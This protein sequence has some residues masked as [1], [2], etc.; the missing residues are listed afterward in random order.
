MKKFVSAVAMALALSSGS[1]LAADL[2]A[3]K[4][5]PPAPPP[6]PPMWTGFYA[7]LNAGY[8]FGT[9]NQV[10]T[11]AFGAADPDAINLFN[12]NGSA[13]AISNLAL[14]GTA[15]ANTGFA[16][17]NQNGF[18][19]GAQIGYNW[20]WGTSFVFGVEADIQGAG[21]RG[22]GGHFGASADTLAFNYVNGG[23]AG[24]AGI[25][26][27]AIG[28]GDITAGIDW[29]GTVRGRLGYA[30][31]SLLLFGTGGLAYGGVHATAFHSL[32]TNLTSFDSR[33]TFCAFGA[34]PTCAFNP[35]SSA[36]FG[37]GGVARFSDTRVGWTAGGGLEWMFM[38]SWSLKAEAL[39][40]DLGTARFASS[41][42]AVPALTGQ[43]LFNIPETRVKYQGVIVRAG[44]NYHFNWGAPAPVVARY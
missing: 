13:N 1:A 29:M 10:G 8:G 4:G 32:G 27:T 22:S 20:Q 43:F 34:A 42:I 36:S 7:G 6:P 31:S 9:S 12:F 18:I 41:P 23:P 16:N 40:Y 3:F 5:P 15:L 25:N 17:V 11:A 2:P 26:R 33:T 38:P 37:P 35:V 21:I 44:V 19:G 24:V 39:Y 30:W 28:S 14:G